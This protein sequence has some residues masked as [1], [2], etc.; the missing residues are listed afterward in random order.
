[1]N[2]D[3]ILIKFREAG[4]PREAFGTTLIKEK[5]PELRAYIQEKKYEAHPICSIVSKDPLP[6]YLVAKEMVLSNFKVFCCE[7]VDV[8]TA[9]FT[10]RDEA[11]QLLDTIEGADVICL[12]GFYESE[13]NVAQFLTPYEMAYFRSWFMRR[14]AGGTKFVLLNDEDIA[15]GATWWSGFFLRYIVRHCRQF[16]GKTK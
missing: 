8:H 15:M 9:L 3:A 13:G 1:M 5:C 10:D 12:S 6:F 16:E 11:E 14:V 2:E 4:I 7:L